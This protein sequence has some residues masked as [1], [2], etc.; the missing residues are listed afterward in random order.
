M[1]G[2]LAG[3]CEQGLT[4]ANARGRPPIDNNPTPS[5]LSLNLGRVTLQAAFASNSPEKCRISGA[6]EG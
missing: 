1:L 5:Y 3:A 6:P 2:W 4:L